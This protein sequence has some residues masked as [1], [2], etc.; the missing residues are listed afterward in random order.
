MSAVLARWL[1]SAAARRAFSP[2][3]LLTAAILIAF[4]VPGVFGHDPWKQDEGYTFGMVLHILESGDWV[5]PTLA[6][7]P[8]MEKPP[9]YYLAA[10]G[11]AHALS[12]L[13]P[14]HEGARAASLI[15]IGLGLAFAGLTARRLFGRTRGGACMLLIAG[16]IGFAQHS[17]EM[18]TD[19]ALFAGF[20]IA[21]YGL[22]LALARPRLAGVL[23][24]TGMGIGFMA[25]GLVEPAMMGLASAA[26]PLAFADWRRQAYVVAM[27]WAA[28]FALPWLLIWP[29]AL[30]AT[31]HALFMEWFWTNNFG[32]YFGFAHLGADTEPWYYTRVLPWFTLPVGPIA[33]W[34]LWK[35]FRGE[36]ADHRR[37]VQLALVLAA[38]IV[39]VLGSAA[40]ARSLYAVPL[41]I[42][43][44]LLA[45]HLVDRLPPLATRFATFAIILL[46]GVVAIALWAIWAHGAF[47]GQ[48]PH[49]E[50]LLRRLPDGFAFEDHIHLVGFG[51]ILTGLWATLCVVRW[52][53]I[54]WLHRWTAS[55][56]LIWGLVMTLALPWIDSGKSF[57]EPFSAM[58]MYLN[59]DSC[60]MSSG[61]GENQRGM[62]HYFAAVKTLAWDGRSKRCPFLVVQLNRASEVPQV[63]ERAWSLLW[64]G[65]RPG[66]HDERFFL[67]EARS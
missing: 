9:L 62:L 22:A 52:N 43:L 31:D 66:E 34:G 28:L 23:L 59:P 1:P 19:T 15:F 51:A 65:S 45:C 5:V 29:I 63:D 49:I 7:E 12:P 57:R 18:I 20:A 46:A 41:L 21:I 33:A 44:A 60:V 11:T 10:A 17:H 40:T 39:A 25:K 42:P 55:V 37:G 67:Y 58:E 53:A 50:P 30:C 24:G 35:F 56:A 14:L 36:A 32:R 27:M 3:R 2:A 6:G 61:L 54:T 64:Q 8:F 26:L 13:M 16:S 38:S 48:P 47:F 4:L